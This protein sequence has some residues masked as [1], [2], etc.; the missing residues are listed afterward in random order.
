MKRPI[1][2]RST[3]V[4]FSALFRILRQPL[5]S[6][7]AVS[8]AAGAAVGEDEVYE[9]TWDSLRKHPVPEWFQDAKFG[10]YAHWGV[11]S[12][13]GYGSEWY[14][15]IMYQ[16]DSDVYKHHAATYGDPSKFGYKDFIPM[17]KAEKFD[18]EEWAELYEKAGAKF[19]GPV[20]EHHDGFSMWAS[21]VNRWNAADT[22][23][24]RDVTGELAAALRKRGIKIITSFHHGYNFQGYYTPGEGWDTAD[25][26]Y[27]DLYGQ[28]KDPR[29]AHE[30]W[31]AKIKEVID[32]YQPDQI[33]F[34]FCLAPIPDEYKRRMA[35]YYYGQEKK[36]GKPVIITRKGDHL[37][38]GVGVLDIERG[39]MGDLAPFLWQTDDSVA[40]NSWGWV[41]NLQLKPAEELV[42]ELIDIVSKNGVLLLN[43]APKADGAI[44]DDQ[45]RLLLEMGAWLQVNGEAIYGTRPWVLYGEGPSLRERGRG[46]EGDKQGPA[47]PSTGPDVRF[48]RRGETLYA[49]SLG[50]PE[51]E[52]ALGSVHVAKAGPDAQATLLGSPAPVGYRV[53]DLQRL[54][55]KTPDLAPEKHP[56]R[57]AYAFRI[58]GF[59]LRGFLAVAVKAREAVL[60]GE[61]IRLEEKTAGNPNIGF[62][63]SPEARAHWLVKVPRAGTYL[64]RGDVAAGA[65]DTQLAVDVNGQTLTVSVAKTADWAIPVAAKLGSLRFDR[66]GVYHLTLRP[67]DPASWKA[68]NVWGLELG[69]VL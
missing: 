9:E 36:W 39:R 31:F 59:D 19:A 22:G 35:A 28:F 21:K 27:A 5:A 24:K 55:I 40:H 45:K 61:S 18:P 68:V 37:P 10:I 11:Y 48:T 69:L 67:A 34:D 23:P 3:P 1:V 42:H 33:W 41:Q 38:E 53:D 56:C 54:V 17:F 44:P 16:K 66:P 4:A 49:I 47:A 14:P 64:L 20:A 25:P 63:N 60:E 57:Y 32:N 30:R 52:L 12:V 6:L 13:P 62:W 46:M 26:Q 7:L 51:G 2:C 65:G 29:T 8:L 43:V 58:S 15:R 50:W